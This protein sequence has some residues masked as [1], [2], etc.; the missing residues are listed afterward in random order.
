MKIGL[1]AKLSNLTVKTVRYYADINIVNPGRNPKT[2]YRSYSSDD[3]AKLQF[4]RKA[5][6][7]NFSID[8]C[9]E[10]LSL[11]QDKNR[12]SKEVKRLTMEKILEID[13]K[14]EELNSLKNQLK[15]LVSNCQGN[16]RPDCPILDALSNDSLS[17]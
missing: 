5:R 10:L 14:L 6:Q 4:V 15:H 8:E 7:F 12:S 2:G 9:R 16:D 11:Y 13:T 17:V 3:V 1:V